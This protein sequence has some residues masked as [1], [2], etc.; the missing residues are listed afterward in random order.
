MGGAVQSR[1][2]E[3][4]AMDQNSARELIALNNRFY[5]EHTASFSATRSAPWDGWRQVVAVAR[6]TGALPTADGHPEDGSHDAGFTQ[7]RYGAG[8]NA[9]GPD[10]RLR[11][12]TAPRILDAACGNRRFERFLAGALGGM[13]F[14][15]HGVDGCGALMDTGARLRGAGVTS[16]PPIGDDTVP[17]PTQ[18]ASSPISSSAQLHVIDILDG[19]LRVTDPFAGVPACELVACFGFMHHVPG[20]GLRAQLVESLL[21]RTVPGG[22]VAL[23]FWRFMDDDRLARKALETGAA[24]GVDGV[25]EPGDHF[26]GWQDDRRALR[27]CHHFDEAEVDALAG[28]AAPLAR[29]IARFSADGTS[30]ALNRYLVLQRAR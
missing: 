14:E 20:S 29:E 8:A 18:D 11:G 25:L 30:G 24:N 16:H 9:A 13:S 6:E 21:R 27:Y 23:S 17:T 2:T 4:E 15:Y 7:A 5:A 12:I 26:L 3:G 28:K 22:V 10:H 19:L 1:A